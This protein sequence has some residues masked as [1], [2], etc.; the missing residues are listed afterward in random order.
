[1]S[2]IAFYGERNL[3]GEFSNFYRH[4][5]F[6]FTFIESFQRSNFPKSIRCNYTEKAI[7]AY[8]ALLMNDIETFNKIIRS[9]NP[10]E[11]K[12]LGREVKNW[13]QQLWDDN[14]EEIAFQV[15]FQKFSKIE[16][17]RDFL[18][19]TKND[20]IVE[21]SPYDKIWGVGLPIK[22]VTY[23]ITKWKG[24]NILGYALMEAREAIRNNTIERTRIPR[25]YD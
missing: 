18:L 1:M 11:T 16:E 10:F 8:K 7:M 21:A 3:N 20:I 19:K 2:I 4:E 6:E 25:H 13:N 22:Y 15:V 24:K 17:F 14:I 9:F 23:D 5:E 12:K